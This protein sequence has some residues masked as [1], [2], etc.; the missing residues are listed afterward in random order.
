M[1]AEPHGRAGFLSRERI[2]ATLREKGIPAEGM[3]LALL[4]MKA[5]LDGL[6][7]SGPRE[8][9]SFT[10]ALL[11]ERAGS[12]PEMAKDEALVEPAVLLLPNYDEFVLA[13]KDR[14]AIRGEGTG[15]GDPVPGNILF[16]NTVLVNGK[17]RGTW[18]LRKKATSAVL[19]C[20]IRSSL[21]DREERALRE[22]VRS[23]ALFL[24]MDQI[25]MER[26]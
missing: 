14:L 2:G 8:G 7:C 1:D 25:A 4:L 15:T 20:E 18:K 19:E 23:L 13:Y 22:T 21:S 26:R 16:R 11:Q 6:I 24:G 9:K 5:E 3:R 10:Y 17:V 12:A